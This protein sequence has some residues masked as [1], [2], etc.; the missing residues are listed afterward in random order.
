MPC[1][2]SLYDSGCRLSG[3]SGSKAT[4]HLSYSDNLPADEPSS[5]RTV[6]MYSS[7]SLPLSLG[8]I[9]NLPGTFVKGEFYKV[10]FS[11]NSFAH[12]SLICNSSC[13]NAKISSSDSL[14]MNAPCNAAAAL[15]LPVGFLLF[16][17]YTRIWSL[18]HPHILI[19]ALLHSYS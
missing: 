18:H 6:P 13:N 17:L 8:I 1:W 3:S 7:F 16:L 19:P 2:N 14:W 5:L 15:I 10:Y 11:N 12:A 9:L 4:F